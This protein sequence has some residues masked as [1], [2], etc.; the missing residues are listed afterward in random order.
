MNNGPPLSSTDKTIRL[1]FHSV[2][3][4]DELHNQPLSV[5]QRRL[6]GDL[7]S[8]ETMSWPLHISRPSLLITPI[9]R[10]RLSVHI[11]FVLS[12]TH[13]VV[14][15][16]ET[17]QSFRLVHS[18]RHFDDETGDRLHVFIVSGRT[19]INMNHIPDEISRSSTTSPLPD[20]FAES[21]Q[22]DVVVTPTPIPRT[23]MT[24]ESARRR[25]HWRQRPSEFLYSDDEDFPS[26][27][28][29]SGQRQRRRLIPAFFDDTHV[30][31]ENMENSRSSSPLT[32]L[33]LVAENEETEEEGEEGEHNTT[34]ITDLGNEEE[35]DDD[36]NINAGN[37]EAE[38]SWFGFKLPI[39]QHIL[40][41]HRW[42]ISSRDHVVK[43]V[44]TYVKN[45]TFQAGPV[46]NTLR[47]IEDEQGQGEGAVR[48]MLTCYFETI[49]NDETMFEG[50]Q[51]YRLPRRN[52]QVKRLDE[53]VQFGQVL[54]VA[55]CQKLTPRGFHPLTVGY[56]FLHLNGLHQMKEL[57]ELKECITLYD[58][59][60]ADCFTKD[61]PH[62]HA[63]DK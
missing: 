24:Y 13:G 41:Y 44:H 9:M 46:V 33:D 35:G 54:A 60:L 15:F 1:L 7:F 2:L 26:L 31:E 10:Q 34:S 58:K 53:F 30:S 52:V 45:A 36:N 19:D 63:F 21:R 27:S 3:S 20:G 18:L 22:R 48:D 17:Q 39:S 50:S 61:L 25:R 38:E 4:I 11:N 59:E 5:W 49:C 51:G 40:P 37:D 47:P 57:S 43:E 6:K 56:G 14:V 42:V 23:E 62:F 28:A 32:S 12:E 8:I 16:F 55:C 29:Q